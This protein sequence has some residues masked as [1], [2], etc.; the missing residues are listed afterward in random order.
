M[1][2]SLQ[3][4]CLKTLTFLGDVL[5]TRQCG[6]QIF[7]R[8]SGKTWHLIWHIFPGHKSNAGV[9]DGEPQRCT[10]SGAF[11][12][13]IILVGRDLVQLCGVLHGGQSYV[14]ADRRLLGHGC[15]T[16]SGWCAVLC[17]WGFVKEGQNWKRASAIC[18]FSDPSWH[19]HLQEGLCQWPWLCSWVTD[20]SSVCTLM[21]LFTYALSSRKAFP[22]LEMRLVQ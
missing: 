2:R 8:P 1:D 6:C 5:S 16:R 17:A 15:V 10:I 7:F 18:C 11:G 20:K 22:R 3:T 19:L 13:R 12:Y 14:N 9:S 21:D 4:S